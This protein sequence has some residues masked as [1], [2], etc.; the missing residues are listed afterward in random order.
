MYL[1]MTNM[2]IYIWPTCFASFFWFLLLLYSLLGTSYKEIK[3]SFLGSWDYN[4]VNTREATCSYGM[5]GLGGKME[6]NAV[7][8]KNS[9]IFT[10]PDVKLRGKWGEI[11]KITLFIWN[12]PISQCSHG[13]YICYMCSHEHEKKPKCSCTWTC[14]LFRNFLNIKYIS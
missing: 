5:V 11:M 1:Y 13:Q 8:V 12:T 9:P 2:Y 3:I 10:F 7:Y 4:Q 6:E 14:L